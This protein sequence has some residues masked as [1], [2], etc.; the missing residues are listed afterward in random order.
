MLSWRERFLIGCGPGVLAGITLTDWLK[1]LRENRS[2]VDSAYLLRA[3]AIS[4]AAAWNSVFQCYEQCRYGRR[5]KDVPV[6]PPL[7]VLGH[8][9]SGTTHLHYLLGLD[10]RFACPNFYQ[11]FFPHTFLSTER[12][13]SGLTAFLLPEH[14]AYDN[15]RLDLKV[16][17]EDEFAMCVSGF[18]TPYLTGVFPRRAAHYDRFLTFRGAPPQA[19]EEWKSSLR[20]LLKKL[21][22]RHGKP[23]ILK[24]PPHTCRIKLLL[25]MFPE[26]RFVHIHRD[27]Y[28]V[29]QSMIHTYATGLPFGRLQRTDE[30]DWAERVIRQYKELYAAFFEERCLIAAGHFHELGFEALEKDPVGEVRQLY[31]ALGLPEFAKVEPTLRAY[32]DSLSGY[33]KNVLPEL[34]PDVRHRIAGEWGRCFEEWGYPV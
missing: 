1:L 34:A 3:V 21:M 29:F 4:F 19:A 33:R 20:L 9:R 15:M 28:A 10:D 2:S 24:S 16:P 8:W 12:R 14:R 5:W 31:E 7:F 32:V 11:V 23:L 22:L 30:V 27:P 6:P 17:C 18:M 26:A 25:G 13:F